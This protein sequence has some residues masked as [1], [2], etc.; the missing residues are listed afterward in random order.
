MALPITFR[1]LPALRQELREFKRIV[2]F[3][4]AISST[5]SLFSGGNFVPFSDFISQGRVIPFVIFSGTHRE[6]LGTSIKV[7]HKPLETGDIFPEHFHRDP[8]TMSFNSFVS[9]YVLLEAGRIFEYVSRVLFGGTG[10]DVANQ[11]ISGADTVLRTVTAYREEA[12]QLIANW[13]KEGRFVRVL[14]AS[15]NAYLLY[16]DVEP[17]F[18]ISNFS[19]NADKDSGTDAY[20]V[21]LEITEAPLVASQSDDEYDIPFI[22]V[23]VPKRSV[24][25]VL[26]F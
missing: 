12:I 8:L 16:D 25:R 5:S 1:N 9:N 7:S 22:G 14:F 26:S 2:M 15:H 17:R 11:L 3:P 6:S 10:A 23:S 21:S 20:A 24:R 4:D 13:Q 19:S 18:Y